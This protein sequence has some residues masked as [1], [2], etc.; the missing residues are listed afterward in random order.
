M[1]LVGISPVRPL[2]RTTLE[3]TL[4]WHTGPSVDR[5]KKLALSLAQNDAAE[6]QSVSS[7]GT[8]TAFETAANR[9][10]KTPIPMKKAPNVIS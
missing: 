1:G 2:D 3:P 10:Q 4:G 7:D 6:Q 9:D 5:K 8:E